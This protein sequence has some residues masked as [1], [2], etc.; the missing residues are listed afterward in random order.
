MLSATKKG[1]LVGLV[2]L[3]VVALL[4]GLE[5][6][7]RDLAAVLA[8]ITVIGSVPALGIGA[9]C[10]W[11]GGRMTEL[12]RLSLVAIPM[13]MVMALGLLSDTS[14]IGPAV[15]PTLLSALGLEYWTRP[16]MSTHTPTAM[17]PA[18]L[19][20]LLGL[21]NVV[22]VAVVLGIYVTRVEP[23]HLVGGISLHPPFGLHFVILVISI[24]AVPG[25]V[26]GGLA[27]YLANHLRH[28]TTL[29][30]LAG[31][32]SVAACGVF[33]LGSLSDSPILVM[34]ALLPTLCG[35]GVLERM[36]RPIEIV[37]AARALRG[38]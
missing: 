23:R 11:L 1:L 10:G 16:N 8:V 36:T 38:A 18:L 26:V 15:L 6:G 37:P 28:H 29:T 7:L 19:G 20:M 33:A 34:P 14:L 22:V 17:T 35:V 21:A 2:N 4:I 27:G 30:R 3:V 24:G 12:R 31:I 32:G 5:E 13:T 25:A 9:L